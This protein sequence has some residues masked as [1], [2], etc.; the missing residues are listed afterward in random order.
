MCGFGE[1]DVLLGMGF[2]VLKIHTRP[3]LFLYLSAT[4]K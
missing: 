1:G 4:Y 2:E 3:S